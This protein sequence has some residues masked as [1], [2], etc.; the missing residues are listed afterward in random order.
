MRTKTILLTAALVAAGVASSMAQSNVYS[1]NVVGYVNVA[2]PTGFSIVNTPLDSGNNVDTNLFPSPANGTILYSF[3]AS[4]GFSP[5]VYANGWSVPGFSLQPGH[6]YFYFNPT[7]N[8]VTNTFVGTVLQGTNTNALATGFSL[9]GSI[10]PISGTVDTNLSMPV[11]NGT[12]VYTF[13]SSATGY[14]P[15]VYAN[16]WTPSSPVIGVGQGFFVFQ[17]AATNWVQ[18]FTV[19]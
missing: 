13:L 6:A 16:G 9:V 10:P 4:G 18:T 1:L 8:P 11:E 5:D 3:T 14:V 7:A 2:L 17:P 15:Y 12:I 19:Q